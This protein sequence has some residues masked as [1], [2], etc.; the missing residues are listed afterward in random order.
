MFNG[1]LFLISSS[2]LKKKQKKSDFF[3]FFLLYL[4]GKNRHGIV[5]KCGYFQLKM[6]PKFGPC[7]RACSDKVI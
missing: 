1:S 6:R 4:I 3:F 2:G 7:R 5:E